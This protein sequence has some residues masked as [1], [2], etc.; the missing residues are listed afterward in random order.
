MSARDGG[1]LSTLTG[2]GSTS[3]ATHVCWQ[4]SSPYGLSDCEPE[5]LA[6]LSSLTKGLNMEVSSFLLHEPIHITAYF[7]IA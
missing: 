3:K 5:L 4:D 6:A 1:L 7:I 2:A